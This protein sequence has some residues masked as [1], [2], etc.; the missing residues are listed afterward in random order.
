M[1]PRAWQMRAPLRP[2]LARGLLSAAPVGIMALADFEFGVSEAGAI[3]VGALLAGFIAFDAPVRERPFWQLAAAPAIGAAGALGALTGEP[4]WL[5]VA[6]MLVVASVGAMGFAVS[7]RL[8][9]V[10]LTVVLALLLGQGVD[11][12]PAEALEVLAL[13]AAGVVLSALASAAAALRRGPAARLDPVAGARAARAAIAVNL[14]LGSP[15]FRHALRWGVAMAVGVAAY[16]VVDLGDHGYWVP[17]TI[18]FVLRPS[19]GETVERIAMRAT[20]TVAGLAIGTPIAE[21]VAVHPILEA[22]VLATAA[23]FS[24]ALLAIEYALF[25]TAITV[26]I[27]IFAHAEGEPAFE[28]ADER[29]LATALGLAI[30]ALAFAAFSNRRIEV[31]RRDRS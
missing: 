16:N 12:D 18:L 19:R 22:V 20:G 2:A 11:P 31:G 28:A 14:G 7:L 1:V 13:G 24:F 6:T 25:T 27:V 17:L 21:L 3:S 9:I 10:A 23:A 30:C 15:S 4:G 29:A 8:A 5:A 26:Y